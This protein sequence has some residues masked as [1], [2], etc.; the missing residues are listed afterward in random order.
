MRRLVLLIVVVFAWAGAAAVS[1]PQKSAMSD[2][3]V[4]APELNGGLGWFNV[5]HPL[6]LKALRGK[7]VLLDFWTYGCINCLHIIPDLKRLEAKYPRQLVVIGVH[8]AKFTNERESENL[9]RIIVRYGIE[10]PVVNDANFSIWRAYAIRAWPTRVLI[11]PDGYIVAVVS[12]E[13]HFEAFDHAIGEIAAEFGARGR[14]DETPLRLALERAKVADLPLSFPGKVLADERTDRLYV[15][16]SNHNRIVVTT[17]DGRL[18]TTIGSGAI[19]HDDG[20]FEEASFN[21]PQGLALETNRGHPGGTLYVADTENHLIRAADLSSR[22]VRTVAGT[23]QQASYGDLDRDQR[24]A[25]DRPLSSPWDLALD[26]RRLFVA[27]AGVHEIWLMDLDAGTIGP[28]AGSGREAR[29]DGTLAESGFAQPSGLAIAGKELFVADPESNIIRAVDLPPGNRVSTLAGG[30][31]FEFG[32]ADGHGDDVRLQHPL[33]LVAVT[34]ADGTTRVYIADTYNHKV[35]VLDPRTRTVLT[36]GGT[37]SPGEKDGTT[38]AR[39][40]EPGGLSAANG[41]LYVADTN[42]HAIRT[43][44]LRTH[45]VSTLRLTGVQPPPTNFYLQTPAASGAVGPE[46]RVKAGTKLVRASQPGEILLDLHLPDGYHLNPLATH[47]YRVQVTPA[48]GTR[49]TVLDIT[50]AQGAGKDVQLPVKIPFR[51]GPPGKGHLTAVLTAYYCREDQTG[52]C[53]IRTI[54][55][56][57]T[58]EVVEDASAPTAVRLEAKVPSS[59]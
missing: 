27:M 16:D 45:Q 56:D 10:H 32:D 2:K 55:W 57:G 19:G 14:L 34:Q 38:G 1:S 54:T 50:K 36:I 3:H 23:G 51:A 26:G 58:V 40:Y 9:R 15:A 29:L 39:F 20:T 18:V 31:L 5:D 17:L 49:G 59:E 52:T 48:N 33:G 4:R 35:K 24:P 13:G 30:D 12:G 25:R 44:D 43:I 41:T 47:S 8:S 53:M 21:R 37:G 6:S 11:D 42:N 46:Q 7:V 28:Y 22:T